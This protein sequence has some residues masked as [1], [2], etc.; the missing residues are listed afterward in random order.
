MGRPH[1]PAA[2]FECLRSETSPY[3]VRA[4][5]Y[6]ELVVRYGLDVPFE[7]DLPVSQQLRVLEKIEAWVARQSST[8]EDGRWYFGGRLQPRASL[9]SWAP[10]ESA[11]SV[12]SA[13][14]SGVP[15]ATD[16]RDYSCI[17]AR[18]SRAS[19]GVRRFFRNRANVS[20]CG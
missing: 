14:D 9:H 12:I 16:P 18:S 11:E 5:T 7:V 2:L 19:F 13:P 4:A 17:F 3:A 15:V 8:F 1:G 20:N 6:E 10:E